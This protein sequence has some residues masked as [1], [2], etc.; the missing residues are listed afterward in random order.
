MASGRQAAIL[1]GGFVLAAT[2]RLASAQRV[3][4]VQVG[5]QTVSIQVGQSTSVF[6]T[7][8]DAN[9]NVLVS[10]QFRW[11]SGD[12]NV[13][14]VETDAAS[15]D[16]ANLIG[17][18]PGVA[19][20]EA[21]IGSQS[22]IVAVQVVGEGGAPPAP[23]ETGAGPVGEATILR[24]E[25]GN[26]LMLPAESRQLVAVFFKND[27]SPAPPVAVSWRS[28]NEAIVTVSQDGLVIAN[29]E[30]QGTIEVATQT[31]L[32]HLAPVRVSQANFGFSAPV[33][34]MS[35][36]SEVTI[37]V[38]VPSQ[39]NRS[40][41]NNALSWRSS[42]V[43]IVRVTPLGFATAVEAGTAQIV[44]SGFLQEHTLQVTVHRPVDA[45]SGLPR[46]SSGPVATPLGGTVQFRVEAQAADSTPVPE[47][48]MVWTVRDTSIATFDAAT[49]VLTG[50]S[51]GETEL[52]LKGPGPDILE[53]TWQITV[54]AGGL[55]ANVQRV[56]IGVRDTFTVDVSF[57]DSTGVPI[58][59]ASSVA[60]SS[61][62]EGVAMVS[63]N[64][65][66]TGVGLG[67]AQI[68]GA[69][70]WE[71]A[72]TVD[73]YVQ[74]DLLITGTREGSPDLFTLDHTN[75][76]ELN[77]VTTDPGVETSGAFSH[78]GSRIAFVSN[79]DGNLEV[80]VANADGSDP[81]RITT[82]E[83]AEGT[84]VWTPDGRQIVYVA[85]APG[86][87][88]QSWI[89]NADGSDPRQLTTGTTT[90]FQ[91]A[92][93]PDGQLIAFTSTRDRNYEIY[94]MGLDGSNQE[95]ATQSEA[96]ESHPAWFPSG[97]LAYI[98][99]LTGGAGI[100]GT[101]MRMSPQEGTSGVT[102]GGLAITGFAISADGGMLALE[103][104]ALD[105]TGISR[106][107][108]L[109]PTGGAGR[110][111]EVPRQSDSEQ[112]Y[113]PSFRPISRN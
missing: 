106:R 96:K 19:R 101:V 9:G 82:T 7:A 31:G 85:R 100:S 113:S 49:Q 97:D 60:W 46:W 87:R 36:G 90:N 76:A 55:L 99:E 39:D 25:P 2:P 18:R 73:V 54:I 92:V 107:I 111:L 88:A 1:V 38:I 93:S 108:M 75:P 74:G 22:G 67:H 27:G 48:P 68:V 81:Q 71:R 94:R 69:T 33:L 91:P 52:H 3:A 32:V 63:Q 23:A 4:E 29:A 35:P 43:D 110:P 13:V 34:S 77:R 11:S 24:I 66:I 53:I 80:Y 20:V 103:V 44:A 26:V 70:P 86:E 8:Y 109:M 15:S 28:L 65:T 12:P 17:V 6:A 21:R 50:R 64:G 105:A 61:S 112:L 5:P 41:P 89:M 83:A 10:Q 95:N 84:P 59:P 72:D 98:A 104:S 37:E 79:R 58:S 102:P 30:G 47:A 40:L 78:D 56:G 16:I 42:N 51:I 45:I 62:D 57:T 14:R